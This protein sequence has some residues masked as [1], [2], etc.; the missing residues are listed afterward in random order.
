MPQN[1]KRLDEILTIAPVIP[2]ITIKDS[3]N[4]IPLARALVKGG[5]PVIEITLRTKSAIEAIKLI[6]QEVKGAIVGAGTVLTASQYKSATRAGASFM[7][8]PGTTPSLLDIAGTHDVPLLPGASSPSESMFLMDRSYLRQK[9]FPAEQSG[10]IDYLSA[11]VSPLPDVKFCPTGGVTL[12]NSTSYL[13]LKN[14][15]CVGGSWIASLDLIKQKNWA[16]IEENARIAA[17]LK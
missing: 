15:L 14:V 9:F 3:S 10:G 7:V 11:L 4:A 12:E 17:S 6:S 1:A 13:K 16:K 8:S 2:V 5:L